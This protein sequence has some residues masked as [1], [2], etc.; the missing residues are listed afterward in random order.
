MD[1]SIPSYLHIWNILKWQLGTGPPCHDLTAWFNSMARDL[2]AKVLFWEFIFL[3]VESETQQ[4]NV[5]RWQVFKEV[6]KWTILKWEGCVW[7]SHRG[8]CSAP[9]E[10]TEGGR[11]CFGAWKDEKKSG[12]SETEL[13]SKSNLIRVGC[14]HIENQ[15]GL[16]REGGRVYTDPSLPSSLPFYGSV[17]HWLDPAGSQKAF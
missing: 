15:P 6:N 16:C 5:R 14:F 11:V 9:E 1:T 17:P 4:Q 8:L 7:K 3:T 12:Y 10:V 2:Q 13:G